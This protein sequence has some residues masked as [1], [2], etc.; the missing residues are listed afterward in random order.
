M[1]TLLL[2]IAIII[3]VLMYKKVEAILRLLLVD[4]KEADL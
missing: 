4:E 2:S 3:L 1:E